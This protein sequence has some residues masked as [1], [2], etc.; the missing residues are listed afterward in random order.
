M[1]DLNKKIE[2]LITQENPLDTLKQIVPEFNHK[3][4]NK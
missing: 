1:F 2:K 3:L 4:N